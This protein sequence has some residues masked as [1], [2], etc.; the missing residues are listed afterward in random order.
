M[1]IQR[2]KIL[3]VALIFFGVVGSLMFFPIQL[4]EGYTCLYHQV[5]DNDHPVWD[6]QGVANQIGEHHTTGMIN[7]YIS[8]YAFF[9]W[10]SLA[11]IA[12]GVYQLRLFKNTNLKN[13]SLNK[14]SNGGLN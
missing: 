9:W 14:Y 13:N 8:G 4:D 12:L 1:I 7:A 10:G 11:L 6:Q 3:M 5:F 2:K